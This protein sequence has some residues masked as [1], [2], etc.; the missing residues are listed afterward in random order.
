MKDLWVKADVA[1]KSAHILLKSGDADGAVSRAHYAMF[2][3]ARAVLA[4]IDP[5]LAR[6]KRHATVLSRFSQHIVRERGL[7]P[8][9]GRIL[10]EAFEARILVDY[11]EAPINAADD[12]EIVAAMDKFLAAVAAL[13]RGY[14]DDQRTSL[15]L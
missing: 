1:A 8:E 15:S 9:I 7:D 13:E 2:D 10:H 14:F 5:E 3:M 11:G 4:H 12:A 6:T